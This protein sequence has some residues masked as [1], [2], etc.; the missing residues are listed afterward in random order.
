MGRLIS[1]TSQQA[2]TKYQKNDKVTK[3]DIS[4]NNLTKLPDLIDKLVNLKELIIHHNRLTSLSWSSQ[5]RLP[6]SIKNLTHLDI[7]SN[8]LTFLPDSITKLTNLVQLDIS[9][10]KLTF[11]PVSIGK[12]VNLTLLDIS[13]N[14]LTKLPK[15]IGKIKNLTHFHIDNNQLKK[16]PESIGR[17]SNLTYLYIYNN[18]LINLPDTIILAIS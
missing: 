7:S 13:H 14:E 10:N 6:G 16:L 15:S 18:N 8:K 17:L 11:L 9:D 3:L 4:F 2:R 12:L 5:A 1:C